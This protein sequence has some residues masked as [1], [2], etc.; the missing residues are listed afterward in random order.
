MHDIRRP[1][2]RL[3]FCSLICLMVL[4]PVLVLSQGPALTTIQDTVYRADGTPAQG[5]L[6]ISW[7]EFSTAGG[8]AVSAGENAVVL[9][10]SGLLNIQLTPN[11]GAIPT[12]TVYTVVYQL[13]DGTVKT[14]YWMVGTSSPET[15]AQVRTELGAGNS[16]QQFATQQYVNGALAGKANDNAVV[17][18][19]GTETVT[20]IKQFSVAPSLPAP[21]NTT[22]AANKAY[23]DSSV[24][25]A[26]SGNFVSKSGDTMTGPLTLPGAPT[27]P[28][29]ATT[30]QY[31]D[32]GLSNKAD[33]VTG[34]VPTGELA[35]GVANNSV[36]LHGD[37][38]WGACGV[39][40][41]AVSIQGVP[42]ATTVPLNNQVLTYS[43][44]LGQYTP[45]AGGGVSAGMQAI[46]YATDFAW[47]QTPSGNLGTPGA[48]TVTLTACPPG[49]TGTEPQYYVYVAGTGTPEAVLVTGGTC[50]GSGLPGTL[51]FTTVN[52][53][54]TG[55]TVSSASSGVQ[56]ALIAARYI[57]QNP[58]GASQAGKVIVPPGE[59][60]AY[61]KISIRSADITVD[62]GGSIVNCYMN[63]TCIL[64]GDLSNSNLYEDITLIG[65]RG[66]PM[67]ASGQFPFIQDSAQKTRLINVSTR[68]GAT[69]GTFSSYVQVNDD[70]SFLL[71]GLDTSLGQVT[72][73][74]GVLCN[75]TV[76]NP[77][78]YAP[79]PFATYPAVGWLKNLNISMQCTGN[80]IDWQS[81]NTLRVSDSVIQGYSQYGVR[82]GTKRGGYGGFVLDNVYEEVGNCS[83][84][85]GAIGH[86]GVIAQGGT[87]KIAGGEGPAGDVPQFANTGSTNNHY[88]VVAHNT[89]YGVS[90]PLYAGFAMTSGA[91]S[92]TITTADIVGASS[93]DL[94]RIVEGGINPEQGPYGTGSYA[95]VTGISRS[96]ACSAG[97]CTFTDPQ[98]SLQSYTVAA[99]T[100]FPQL[101]FWPGSLVLGTNGDSGSITTA[102]RAWLQTTPSLMVG[103]QGTAEP[104][105]SAT[106]CDAMSGW[107]PLWVSCYT[108]MAPTTFYQQGALLMA[109]KPNNDG[110]NA[111]NLKGRV[112]FATLGSGPGHIITLS[113][114]NFQKT[115]ATA[116]NRPTNDAMDAF[117]GYDQGDGDP[118]QIGISIG[119][120]LSLSNYIGNAGDGTNWQERL[121]AGL[122][123][124]KA[125]VQMDSSLSVAGTVTA[126]TYVANGT[127]PFSLLGNFG[128]LTTAPVGKSLIGFG[129]NGLVQVSENGGPI[130]T[131]A[132]L[133]N[134]GYLEG[135]ALTA[136]ALQATPTQCN[137]SYSTGVQANGNANCSTAS[138]VQLAETSPPPGIANYGLFWF[139]ST[140]HCPKVLDNN[141]QSVQLGLVNVFNTDAN[142]IEED[143][144]L[145][146]Q[147]L[148]VY[149]TRADASDYERLRLGFDSTD[150]YFVVGSDA[151]GTGTQRGLGFWLQGSLRWVIDAS[152]NLKPWSDNVK[153][154]GAETLRPKHVYAGTY[155]DTT[156]GALATDLPNATSVGTTV[157]KLAKLSG[158]PATA[159]ITATSDISGVVGV[160]VDGA[161]T[162][163]SAQIA[164][165]GQAS[166]VFDGAT[167]ANDYVQISA[168]TAGDCH[169]AG[170]S[171]PGSGQ[172]VGRVLSSNGAAGTYAILVSGNDIPA[173]GASFPTMTP[174]G[175][176]LAASSSSITSTTARLDA[177]QFA[178]SD[179]FGKI[180]ACLAALP[181][182]GGACDASN[183]GATAS[184]ST[185]LAILQSNVRLEFG[186][187]AFTAAAGTQI[188]ISGSNVEFRCLGGST[189]FNFSATAGSGT[190]GT[191]L[192]SPNVNITGNNVRV[193]GCSI[194]G[195]RLGSGDTYS[196][197]Q[198]IKA[199]GV[200]GLVIEDNVVSQC[201][202][203][204]IAVNNSDQFIIQRNTTI[205]T[206]GPG[207]N[208]NSSSGGPYYG[209]K[210]VKDNQV[211]EGVTSVGLIGT[212][213]A[214]PNGN[215]EL[216]V[217]S[218]G[219]WGK[220][221]NIRVLDN[222]IANDY[223]CTAGTG[224]DNSMSRDACQGAGT[225]Q[226]TG[227]VG[228]MQV[229]ATNDYEVAGNIVRNT[230]AEGIAVSGT[231][232]NVHDN[233]ESLIHVNSSGA[234]V[235]NG[236]GCVSFFVSNAN[237]SS[238][239][240][241]GDSKI[242]DNHC[243]D[244]GYVVQIILGQNTTADGL[245]LE[246]LD[247]HNNHGIAVSTA[248]KSGIKIV[249]ATAVGMPCGGATR[250]CNWT[251]TNSNFS[252]NDVSAANNPFNLDTTG[253]TDTTGW[254]TIGPSGWIGTA[255]V[256]QL[257]L[258][259][260][261]GFIS[262]AGSV[263]N[264]QLASS[265]F[266]VGSNF[267]ATNTVPLNTTTSHANLFGITI[268]Q[269]VIA[270]QITFEIV[271]ADNTTNTYD[272]GIYTG[273]AGTSDSLI[274]HTGAVAGTTYFASANTFVTVPFTAAVT[275]QPGRYYLALYAN[276]ASAPLTL[277]SNNSADV[278]FYHNS[279]FSITPLSGGLPTSI[280][281]PT[282]GFGAPFT[283]Y[284][285]LH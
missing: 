154:I 243:Y 17:H 232:G 99:P 115:I 29:Q 226:A 218:S 62:F 100:Y 88:F 92:I 132:L 204:G 101:D 213:P 46:K 255:P 105:A 12:N 184:V 212:Y 241:Q 1:M 16:T 244:A 220:T 7:P 234:V 259:S 189:N 165:S 267:S 113:D 254:S 78:V 136:T 175:S 228:G 221:R 41:N 38:S 230:Q 44:S 95:V 59:F 34:L 203:E 223:A 283:P 202:A 248:L 268:R 257:P 231:G 145:N 174:G 2:G 253:L 103:V 192:T 9:G 35:G 227:C 56:E 235:D 106:N 66:R 182:T 83:N 126:S 246:N 225:A 64:I 270:S 73:N 48:V 258:Q 107:T 262:G 152:Y 36:C 185:T 178:G 273:G 118:T 3:Y 271:A 153:D 63:D 24:E 19:S 112:N 139:D 82:A 117:I 129:N 133:D 134:G 51:Q 119:A 210:L 201:G 282:D 224:C 157:N 108:A 187:T 160:V 85:T 42:V 26:G 10:T 209:L 242:H 168:I 76:C 45:T 18:L 276:E 250:A 21:V 285:I 236:S 124:F 205:Q 93:F 131:V 4:V 180:N 238:P 177:S 80:G 208:V 57:P 141:G 84:P 72:G 197:S 272:I 122:K 261:G 90:N 47:T 96:S 166:C 33:L 77:V 264:V 229:L 176:I 69:N 194:Q 207:I 200:T 86:A 162:S 75:A 54:S 191:P 274:A 245:I 61:A 240:S 150:S 190:P 130:S 196:G 266:P 8:Q 14:E 256:A 237:A 144:L 171:Y 179:G 215:Y 50:A 114:S 198:C 170:A 183:L 140:C 219:G 68:V 30:K 181:S 284:L 217:V 31:A 269:A 74:S 142:T 25:N 58:P 111:L 222:T 71:D 151:A 279:S 214:I 37:S 89:T 70:E 120:P 199:A 265:W 260:V 147:T 163:G 104:A 110:G 127:G 60:N 128:P 81:G 249:N 188:L 23:V 252:D 94:L 97:V 149:G 167:T 169:D 206:S 263:A 5:T 251:I 40:G 159:L 211:Y 87:V 233:E 20:G 27:A 52:A 125:T 278:D 79:G 193:R 158:T 156:S 91:G 13:D 135:N 138:I 172:V 247:V 28:N 65:P 280:T 148:N 216:N 43:G 67:V 143:N 49:V 146:P 39:S 53:H 55:Y 277:A 281:G 32:A 275:L 116:N 137:G 173:P 195:N 186:A 11:V 155:V 121:T 98:T 6:L 22:D 161:G 123:E 15:I 102:A 164:R 239:T 109:V